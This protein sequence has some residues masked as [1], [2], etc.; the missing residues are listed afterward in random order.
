MIPLPVYHGDVCGSLLGAML[1]PNDRAK[2]ESFT[3]NLLTKRP[4]QDYLREGYE[5]TSTRNIALFDALGREIASEEIEAQWLHGQRAG[6]VVKTL[7]ALIRSRPEI[8]SWDSAIWVA[9][10]VA[11]SPHSRGTSCLVPHVFL[12]L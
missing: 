7:W 1:F 8:A 5:I 10:D 6:E 9:E 4:L 12:R 2:A 11:A 3:A